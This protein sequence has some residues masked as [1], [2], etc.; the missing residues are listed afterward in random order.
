MVGKSEGEKTVIVPEPETVSG[1][2]RQSSWIKKLRGGR[3]KKRG[4]ER[5]V[6]LVKKHEPGGPLSP[7]DKKE[8]TTKEISG[9]G[10]KVYWGKAKWASMQSLGRKVG[11]RSAS[12]FRIE[13]GISN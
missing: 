6:H 5:K 13:G 10:G 1:R 3:E 2:K 9:K 4:L 11:R 12:A 8:A 7:V